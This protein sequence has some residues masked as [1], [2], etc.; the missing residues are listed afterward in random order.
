MEVEGRR[1]VAADIAELLR[2]RTSLIAAQ[3]RRLAVCHAD[4]DIIEYLRPMSSLS[5]SVLATA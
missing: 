4:R 2:E 1:V 5:T 3:S